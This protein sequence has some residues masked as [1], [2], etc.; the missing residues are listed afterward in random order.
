MVVETLTLRGGA[1]AP[2][3]TVCVNSS[4]FKNLKSR[5]F[6]KLQT[7]CLSLR[8]SDEAERYLGNKA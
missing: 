3:V 5:G 8:T 7:Y 6:G 2:A 1:P 4:L